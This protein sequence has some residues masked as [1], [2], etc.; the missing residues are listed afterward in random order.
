MT[1]AEMYDSI[2]ASYAFT[3]D[4]KKFLETERNFIIR[5]NAHTNPKAVSVREEKAKFAEIVF[6]EMVPATEYQ[7]SDMLNSFVCVDKSKVTPQR[8]THIVGLLCDA[9]KV[10]RTC[11]KGKTTY[12][13]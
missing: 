11:I 3:E 9:G 2:L 4:E 6:A 8:L 12:S 13:R 7:I 10:K 5:A 1:K